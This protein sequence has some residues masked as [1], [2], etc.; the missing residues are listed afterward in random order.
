MTLHE[1]IDLLHGDC[2]GRLNAMHW[3]Y[4]DMAMHLE[5][6]GETLEDCANTLRRI[7]CA[8]SGGN[9]PGTTGEAA[10]VGNQ[11]MHGRVQ[12]CIVDPGRPAGAAM[13]G[14]AVRL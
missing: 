7:G 12:P 2:V 4:V 14:A 13:A 10:A 8:T 6:I 3:A 5:L 9:H 1:E 11:V